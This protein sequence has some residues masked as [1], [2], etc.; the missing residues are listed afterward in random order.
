MRQ[1]LDE[2]HRP[3]PTDCA[4]AGAAAHGRRRAWREAI[5]VALAASMIAVAMAPGKA[6]LAAPKKALGDYSQTCQDEHLRCLNQCQKDYSRDADIRACFGVCD[7]WLD[8][9]CDKTFPKARVKLP[10]SVRPPDGGVLEPYTGPTLH[11]PKVAP[12]G[13]IGQ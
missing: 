10:E 1:C 2:R 8:D 5:H 6:V 11:V 9:A 3:V 4:R 7:D 13:A 12:E